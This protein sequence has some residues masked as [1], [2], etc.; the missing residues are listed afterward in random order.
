MN[1]PERVEHMGR[2]RVGRFTRKTLAFSK[3]P[4]NAAGCLRVFFNDDNL[5][6]T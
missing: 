5:A 3:Y 4:R 2:Q 1:G 6:F